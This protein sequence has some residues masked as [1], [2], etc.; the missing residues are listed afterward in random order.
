MH[1]LFL[2]ES[3]QIDQ[4]GLFALGGIAV[5]DTDWPELR[6]VWQETLSAAGWP[7]DREIKWHGIRKGEVPPALADAVFAMLAVAPFT[8]Y[9]TLLD[10]ELGPEREPD[11]FHTP[12]TRV[13]AR[14]RRG[15]HRSGRPWICGR[16]Q[17]GYRRGCA[18]A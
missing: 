11:F 8:A 2:D 15:A 13:R 17:A 6:R 16:R 4:G 7:L 14:T 10:L 3:G 9:V 12:A 5:R 1:L 18:A